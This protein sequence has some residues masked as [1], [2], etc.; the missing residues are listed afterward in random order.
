MLDAA[1]PFNDIGVP[2]SRITLDG[3]VTVL[4]SVRF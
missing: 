3:G 1:L 4:S 2:F